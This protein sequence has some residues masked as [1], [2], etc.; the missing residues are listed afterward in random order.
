MRRILNE[1]IAYLLYLQ[2]AC[3]ALHNLCRR[4]NSCSS[5]C[6]HV[7]CFHVDL[8][9]PDGSFVFLSLALQDDGQSLGKC[10]ICLQASKENN[11]YH[12]H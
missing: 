4:W 8:R 5:K 9:T 6:M 1:E 3:H 2:H 12:I 10:N 7:I 11:S